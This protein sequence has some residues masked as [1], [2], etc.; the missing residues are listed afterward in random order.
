MSKKTARRG[1]RSAR[2]AD[3]CFVHV[4]RRALTRFTFDLTRA[5]YD[6]LVRAVQNG[7]C[8]FMWRESNSR[9]HWLV[10][11]GD[12]YASAV[13]NERTRAVSTLMNEEQV[14]QNLL[15]YGLNWDDLPLAK[16]FAVTNPAPK[17]PKPT[18]NTT[19]VP[20]A[21]LPAWASVA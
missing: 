11:V 21:E 5:G 7:N 17:P 16:A 2:T 19:F 18:A 4:Q 10:R 6:R 12:H 8:H 15:S 14:R 9:T 1:L 20:R 13:F 3:D